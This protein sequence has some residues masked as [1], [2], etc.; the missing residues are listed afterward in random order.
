MQPYPRQPHSWSLS[1]WLIGAAA[2]IIGTQEKA[3]N[4]K[5]SK[6]TEAAQLAGGAPQT[7]VKHSW[8]SAYFAI[9]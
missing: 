2:V 1:N 6:Q 3:L 5:H 7:C 9:Q 8:S 4:F